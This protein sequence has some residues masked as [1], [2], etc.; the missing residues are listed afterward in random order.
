MLLLADSLS[1]AQMWM[2]SIQKARLELKE[3]G[4]RLFKVYNDLSVYKVKWYKE[5]TYQ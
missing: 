3:M 1:F 5:K 4:F 2:N